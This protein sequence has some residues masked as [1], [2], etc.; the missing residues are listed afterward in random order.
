[1]NRRDFFRLVSAS[2]VAGA[3]RQSARTPIAAASEVTSPGPRPDVVFFFPD[4]WNPRCL[5]YESDPNV[6]TPNLDRLAREGIIF[7]NNYSCCPVC[8]PAR[9]SLISGLYPHNHGLWM[10]SSNFYVPPHRAPMFRDIRSAGYTTA[11]IGKCHWRGGRDWKREF[12]TVA[13]Y[14]EALGLDH[15]Q[16]IATPFTTP[17][18]SGGPYREHVKKLGLMEAYDRDMADRFEKGQYA[19]VRPSV[20]PPEHH[21]DSFVAQ[22]SIEFIQQQPTDK[23]FALV[24]G[25]PGPHTPLD[26]PGR[27]ATMYDP[28]SIELPVTVPDKM[29]S[30]GRIYTRDDI[31]ERRANYFG[32]ISLLDDCIGQVIDSLKERGNW[33]NTLV[34]FSADHGEMIGAHGKF[35]KSQ[36]WEESVRVPLLMRWPGR[37]P[38]GRRT[39]ALAQLMDIYPTIVEAIGGELSEGN[40]AKS[41]LPIA[42]GRVEET[43]DAVFGEI[44][45]A[46]PLRYMVRTPQHKWWVDRGGEHLYDLVNDPYETEDLVN[47]DSH[48]GV[49]AEIKERHYRYLMETQY[50]YAAGYIPLFQRVK[51]EA[52]K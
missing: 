19:V 26:A 41:L 6:R 45:S 49:A 9:C 46:F 30:G 5:G 47:S 44:G 43:R 4:Q 21:N 39:E 37:I 33:G 15:C 34:V 22:K 25:F 31:R 48:R 20:M 12:E 23:P 32:K 16:E 7:D 28:G 13:D 24:V 40:F 14:Y 27:Y 18:G 36:F 3:L 52:K 35:S 11:Q 17:R 8:M 2:M 50:N 38:P 29:K 42:T 1:M 10:N 51:Q